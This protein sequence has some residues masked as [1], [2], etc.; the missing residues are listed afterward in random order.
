[1]IKLIDIFGNN[2]G[3]L[4]NDKHIPTRNSSIKFEERYYRVGEICYDDDSGDIYLLVE[5]CRPPFM[6]EPIP[7]GQMERVMYYARH[8]EKLKAVKMYKEL[9]GLDLRSAKEYVD[10]LV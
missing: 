3:S 6:I 2:L 4:L 7:E 10:S 8:G 9:T 5:V 1:M